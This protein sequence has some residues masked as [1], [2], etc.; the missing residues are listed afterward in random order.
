[1]TTYTYG[2]SMAA[3]MLDALKQAGVS[4]D[5]QLRRMHNLD[6]EIRQQ[7]AAKEAELERIKAARRT[8]HVKATY[9]PD[10]IMLAEIMTLNIPIDPEWRAHR[11]ALLDDLDRHE[12]RGKYTHTVAHRHL[13]A[14]S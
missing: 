5:E 13:R 4:V 9:K 12:R 11:R 6:Q 1:M 8:L 7:T 10:P 14:V 2:E 3:H